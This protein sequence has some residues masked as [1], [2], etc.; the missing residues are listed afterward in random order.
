MKNVKKRKMNIRTKKYALMASLLSA[1]L[2]L[3]GCM[4]FDL[5]TGAPQGFFSELVH[6]FL[7]IPLQFVL[8]YLGDFLGNYALAIVVFTILFRLVLLPLTLRQQ[9]GMIESQTKMATVQPVINEI[10]EEMK[11][12]EDP[13]EKQAL[14]L[15]LMEVYKDNDVSLGGQLSSGCLPLLLQMPIFIAMIQVM[16]QSEAIKSASLFGISLGE[17]SIILAVITGLV[18][19]LQSKVMIAGMPE[20]QR[21]TAGATMYMSPVMMFMIG[22]SS[23]AGIS[24]YWLISGVFTFFQQLFNTYYYKPRIEKEV[25]DRLGD[26]EV[27]ERKGAK[28][29][30]VSPAADSKTI[31]QPE[32][33]RNRN[34]NAG[35]N[36]GRQQNNRNNQ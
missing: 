13:T 16:R 24:L 22:V 11:A 36:A 28:R 26:L 12:T 31:S 32:T 33:P 7:I 25:K 3:S 29:R 21:K 30:D 4:R 2:F 20:E 1:T 14:Q 15:E 19:F 5:E 8:N 23:P 35:R 6:D 18:Y 10:Q 17:T 27:V 34:R 9:K